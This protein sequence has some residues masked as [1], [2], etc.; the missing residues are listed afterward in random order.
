VGELENIFVRIL[1]AHWNI[2]AFVSESDPGVWVGNN[3]ITAVGIAVQQKV[4]LH[5][6]AFNVNP[7]LSYFSGI[8]PCVI[9]GDGR[10]V[11]SLAQEL[12][13]LPQPDLFQR[14]RQAVLDEFVR[15]YGYSEVV[16]T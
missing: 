13:S 6:F 12:K 14:A 9:S 11:T 16:S 4:S 8:I 5:G 2:N 1:K 10:W 15:T 7:D 3:K